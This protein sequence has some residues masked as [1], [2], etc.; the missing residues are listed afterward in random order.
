MLR[1]TKQLFVILTL[2]LMVNTLVVSAQSGKLARAHQ[3]Y[4][5]L[6]YSDAIELYTSVLNDMEDFEAMWKLANCYRLTNQYQDAEYWYGKV[7]ASTEVLPEHMLYYAQ[8][9]QTNEKYTEAEKW[10]GRFKEEVPSDV[11]AHNQQ[12]EQRL[13]Q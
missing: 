7:T 12:V 8:V 2:G 13:R 6:A 3:A 9:L 11:R 1:N 4:E 10:Y 5:Q